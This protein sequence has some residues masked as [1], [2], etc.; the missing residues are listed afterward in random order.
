MIQYTFYYHKKC[1][2]NLILKIFQ[3]ESN[4]KPLL[5]GHLFLV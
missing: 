5:L 4:Q 3:D 1:I 2:N